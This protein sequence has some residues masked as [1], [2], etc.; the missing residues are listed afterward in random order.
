MF[1]RNY[2]QQGINKMSKGLST[3]TRNVALGTKTA[4]PDDSCRAV[5]LFCDDSNGVVFSSNGGGDF[6]CLANGSVLVYCSNA[7]DISVAG[8]GTLYYLVHK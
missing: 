1:G 3:V 8:S 7:K 2:D 5:E 4:L 6:S